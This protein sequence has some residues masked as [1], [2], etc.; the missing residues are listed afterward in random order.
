MSNLSTG[1]MLMAVGMVTVLVILLIV[2]YFGKLLIATVNKFS[3]PDN[4][5]PQVSAQASAPAPAPAAVPAQATPAAPAATEAAPGL[6]DLVTPIGGRFTL[7][8]GSDGSKPSLPFRFSKG[9]ELCR[10]T[11]ADGENTLCA[12][13]DGTILAVL[14]ENG[15]RVETNE[16]LMNIGK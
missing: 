14:V 6:F 13:E 4:A 5:G 11:T 8:A 9:D 1:L 15:S 12:S 3:S 2:I 7:S 10:I 16:V